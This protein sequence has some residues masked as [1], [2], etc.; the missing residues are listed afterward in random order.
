MKAAATCRPFRGNQGHLDGVDDLRQQR[1]EP[2]LCA[3]FCSGEGTAMPTGLRALSRNPAMRCSAFSA[4]KPH[5]PR[6]PR[7]PALLTAAANAGVL[8]E[9]IGACRIGQRRFSR[10]VS[11]LRGHIVLLQ[12]M[13][14]RNAVSLTYCPVGTGSRPALSSN[15]S[16]SDRPF[17]KHVEL[18]SRR[19]CSGRNARVDASLTAFGSSHGAHSW[20]QQPLAKRMHHPCSPSP[21]RSPSREASAFTRSS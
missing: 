20:I 8:I 10:S 18:A 5:I 14:W 7:P 12:Y 1:Q 2:G 9:P 19:L 6:P 16:K 4:E 17:D 13:G 15:V 3:H 11:A 21:R